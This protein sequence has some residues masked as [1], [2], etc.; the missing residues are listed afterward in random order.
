MSAKSVARS[1]KKLRKPTAAERADRHVLYQRSV[2]D[3]DW[4]IDFMSGLYKGMRGRAAKRLREDFCGTGLFSCAWVKSAPDREAVGIDLDPEVLAWSRTHNL[5]KLR[6]GAL[7]R[8]EL[9]QADV[10]NVKAEPEDIVCAF[11]FSYWIFK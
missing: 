11:N 3:A 4:E 2:Q 8:L 10:M 9:L 6:P 7:R 5:A 1:P